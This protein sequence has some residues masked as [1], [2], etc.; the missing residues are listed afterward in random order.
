MNKRHLLFCALLYC[1]AIT[2]SACQ[3]Q[4]IKPAT[5]T[6]ASMANSSAHTV[7]NPAATIIAIPTQNPIATPNFYI[8]GK[9]GIN[10]ITPEGRT[11]TTAFYT[12]RQEQERFAIEL[13]GVLGMGATHIS[14]NGQTATLTNTHGVL[15][16]PSPSQLL[17]K[18]T[19]WQAPID[20]LPYWIMGK[21]A[22]SDSDSRFEDN[23]L[24]Q[25]TNGQWTVK[26]DYTAPQTTPSRLIATH[27]DG[28]RFVMTINTIQSP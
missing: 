8:T 19:G 20:S 3:S 2:L 12:W 22:E 13:T 6:S 15:N 28:H 17:S 16:A 5:P 25:S 27:V 23:T 26:F 9:I 14:Y 11:A 24:T 7:S 21:T 1:G 10:T 4:S 18:A